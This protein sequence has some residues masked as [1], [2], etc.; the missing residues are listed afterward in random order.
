VRVNTKYER[1][2]WTRGQS[3]IARTVVTKQSLTSGLMF[4]ESRT[5]YSL[6]IDWPDT[7]RA[8]N[9]DTSS[10]GYLIFGESRLP[11]AGWLGIIPVDESM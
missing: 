1:P 4:Y 11:Q 5:F 3:V 6:K 2:Q 7:I 10:Q 8:G 9:D